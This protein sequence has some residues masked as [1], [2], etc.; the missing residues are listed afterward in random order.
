MNGGL[1]Q[2]PITAI[3]AERPQV[4]HQVLYRLMQVITHLA[5]DQPNTIGL[6]LIRQV[7]RNRASVLGS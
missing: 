6:H 7:S 3:A 4:L 1:R 2:G 5:T